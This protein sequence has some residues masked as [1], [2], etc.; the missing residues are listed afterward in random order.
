VTGE[1]EAKIIALNR[2][3]PPVGHSRWTLRL[4]EERS[5]V[6]LGV[7]LS[8]SALWGVLKKTP[9]KPHLKKC[10]CIP[11]KQNAAF[12]ANREDVLEVY[13]RPYDERRPVICMDEQPVQLFGEKRGADNLKGSLSR[14]GRT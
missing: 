4:P 10:R 8:D 7:E 11:P 2:S 9:L 14:M 13:H 1:I 5:T 3:E 6:E 12:A